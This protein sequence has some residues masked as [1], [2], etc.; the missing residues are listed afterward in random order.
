MSKQERDQ[1]CQAATSSPPTEAPAT[2]RS[3]PMPTT[4][5]APNEQVPEEC[6]AASPALSH[7][8]ASAGRTG[9][10][11]ETSSDEALTYSK[12]APG[13]S[14]GV[15]SD[16][17]ASH[18]IRRSPPVQRAKKGVPNAA[19]TTAAAAAATTP[20]S[21]ASRSLSTSPTAQHHGSIGLKTPTITTQPVPLLVMPLGAAQESSASGSSSDEPTTSS[22]GSIARVHRRSSHKH[23]SSTSSHHSRHSG[24]HHSR[25][26][27]SAHVIRTPKVSSS[28]RTQTDSPDIGFC[29]DEDDLDQQEQQQQQ[30]EQQN[31]STD[32][33]P[34]SGK[35][36]RPQQRRRPKK[37]FL[38]VN[39]KMPRTAPAVEEHQGVPAPRALLESPK[40]HQ[41]DAEE[42]RGAIQRAQETR[43]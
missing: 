4:L 42:N 32:D 2:A 16:S 3:E 15:F 33:C 29:D 13:R 37:K 5:H 17:G 14:A 8:D 18:L 10:E 9:E 26:D 34:K 1:Q 36:G 25:H 11:G 41:L 20:T 7:D 23:H 19:T 21:V 31:G 38:S 30:Q 24:S 35:E 39:D 28:L 12:E 43:L 6:G 22:K 27:S 40:P